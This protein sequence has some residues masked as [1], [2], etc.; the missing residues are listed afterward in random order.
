MFIVSITASSACPPLM[1]NPISDAGERHCMIRGT[2]SQTHPANARAITLLCQLTVYQ[3]ANAVAYQMVMHPLRQVLSTSYSYTDLVGHAAGTR[4]KAVFMVN[5]DD[6]RNELR[7]FKSFS[8]VIS[9]VDAINSQ[10]TKKAIYPFSVSFAPISRLCC[11]GGT[12]NH[13]QSALHE[14]Q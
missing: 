11:A 4:A 1:L 10:A 8:H 13:W 12:R 7:S 2:S 5:E 14:D 9:K 3:D 6:G